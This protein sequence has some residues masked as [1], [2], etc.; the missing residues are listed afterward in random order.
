[1]GEDYS[2]DY[3][4]DAEFIMNNKDNLLE[5]NYETLAPLNK[6]PSI[7][8]KTNSLVSKGSWHAFSFKGA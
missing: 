3:L 4:E 7:F 1:M 5:I 6:I 2:N 8:H